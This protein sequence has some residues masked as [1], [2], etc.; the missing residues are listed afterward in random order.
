MDK[1]L[2]FKMNQ[3]FLDFFVHKL[4]PQ[5]KSF[6]NCIM[7]WICESKQIIFMDSKDESMDTWF[8]DTIPA[9][10]LNYHFKMKQ[11]LSQAISLLYLFPSFCI[12]LYILHIEKNIIHN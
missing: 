8:I 2:R 12:K 7:N 9:N 1:S 3:T 4:N 5:I 10:L 11:H 6:E